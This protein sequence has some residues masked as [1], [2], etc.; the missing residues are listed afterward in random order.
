MRSIRCRRGAYT[1]LTDAGR[2]R[3]REARA[4]YDATLSAALDELAATDPAHA[5]VAAAARASV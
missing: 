4:T 3:Y 2:D 1:V 5:A